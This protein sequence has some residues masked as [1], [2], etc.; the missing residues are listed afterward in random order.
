MSVQSP[1][2]L[3]LKRKFAR[4]T[5]IM[6]IIIL[7]LG[8]GWYME[9]K[10]AKEFSNQLSR[11]NMELYGAQMLIRDAE[12]ETDSLRTQLTRLKENPPVTQGESVTVKDTVKPQ[13][14]TK[15]EVVATKSVTPPPKAEA[16]VRYVTVPAD[17]DEFEERIEELESEVDSLR[18]QLAE[19]E[20][21]SS[22]E[23]ASLAEDL[24]LA[25][26]RLGREIDRFEYGENWRDVV[27]DV[28]Y[29]QSRVSRAARSLE[30]ALP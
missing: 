8:Y 7:A 23:L 21:N 25:I 24:I 3:L 10:Q 6:G 27:P 15:K 22:S 1:D 17:T 29:E 30:G 9:Y 2:T 26:K 19:A 28:Q 13:T 4:I 5:W 20:D 14:K 18:D 11:K 12:L 16:D